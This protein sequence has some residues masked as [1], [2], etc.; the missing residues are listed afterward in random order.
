MHPVLLGILL[1]LANVI[2]AAC[3]FAL[4]QDSRAAGF[5]FA[6]GVLPGIC[7]GS[8]LGVFAAAMRKTTPLVRFIFLALPAVLVVVSLG[9]FFYA[10]EFI[11]LALV[12]TLAGCAVLERFSRTA[13][14]EAGRR[15][16]V[17]VAMVLGVATTLVIMAGLF[18]D[19]RDASSFIQAYLPW[20]LG[21][22]L[23]L[24]APFGL[25]A[26]VT[27]RQPI[28]LRRTL[29]VTLAIGVT[30]VLVGMLVHGEHM[31]ALASIPSVVACLLLE[32]YSRVVP[33]L[34][35]AVSRRA[36]S[37]G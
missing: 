29:L 35:I 37:F 30:T 9:T 25:I 1:G 21:C 22:G 33:L 27:R 13:A 34:P 17:G 24:S 26:D 12:P 28:W 23:G 20:G 16:S 14:T 2:A 18:K 8:L 32:R 3:L 19:A 4:T 31:I 36:S 11:P 5:V 10:T 6:Y 7:T 15:S